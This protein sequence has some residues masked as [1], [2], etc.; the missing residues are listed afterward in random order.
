MEGESEALGGPAFDLVVV[1]DLVDSFENVLLYR[2]PC[3]CKQL[4]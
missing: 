4:V 2:V 3:S 1:A